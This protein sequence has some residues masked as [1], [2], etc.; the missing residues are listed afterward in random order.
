MIVTL[1][2]ENCDSAHEWTGK[3]SEK[4]AS[5]SDDQSVFKSYQDGSKS[6]TKNSG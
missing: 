6:A 5:S 2:D 4:G 1:R 3:Q